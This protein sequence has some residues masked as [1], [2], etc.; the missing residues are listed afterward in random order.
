M[1]KSQLARLSEC[2]WPKGE[3]RDVWMILDGARHVRVFETLLESSFLSSCLYAGFVPRALEASAPYLIQLEHEDRQTQRL[4]D[5]AWG[6][7]WG[8]ILRCDTRLEALRKHLRAFLTVRDAKGERLL[9]RYYDPR[10]L[11]V[12]LPTCT[13]EELRT[14]FGPIEQFWTEGETSGELLQFS[15]EGS[16][17]IQLKLSLDATEKLQPARPMAEYRAPL[18][19]YPGMLLVRSE[20]MAVFSA[21][22]EKE[23]EDWMVAHLNR[24][25]ADRCKR[26]GEEALRELI[27]YGIHR[28]ASYGLTIR[29]EVCK[30]IDVMLVLGRD[31]DKDPRHERA[32]QILMGGGGQPGK[33]QAL[34]DWAR[35]ELR[36]TVRT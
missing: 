15:L 17:L 2:L 1:T 20:Q 29:R 6:N 7:S 25:F 3:R 14:L 27:R 12:Y 36:A 18:R 35:A 33:G 30:Y 34:I 13:G 16:K 11:R 28:A 24:F 23:F 9:F 4:L 10:V 26:M 32:R 22:A 31:F 8:V 19:R 5:R 21:A